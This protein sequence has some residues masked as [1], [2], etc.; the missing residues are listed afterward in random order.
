MEH[1]CDACRYDLAATP[2]ADGV[3]RCPECGRDNPPE[4]TPAEVN[5]RRWVLVSAAIILWH[6]TALV[7]VSFLPNLFSALGQPI[8]W[9]VFVL[10]LVAEQTLATLALLSVKRADA[11][12][13]RRL[14]ILRPAVVWQCL[15]LSIG[16]TG[17]AVVLLFSVGPIVDFLAR[18]HR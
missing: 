9:L 13:G 3:K 14:F 17:V 12:K 1:L 5:W 8:Q 10:G 6:A 2:V 16:L 4:A 7:G 11:A 15:Q 18:S